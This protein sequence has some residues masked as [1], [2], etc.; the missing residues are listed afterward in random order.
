VTHTGSGRTR[1]INRIEIPL[2]VKDF[3]EYILTTP[4]IAPGLPQGLA[5]FFMRLLIPDEKSGFNAI[6][7]ET[8]EPLQQN[9]LPFILDIDVFREAAFEIHATEMWDTLERLRDFKNEIFFKS[10]TQ[11]A[12]ELFK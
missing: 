2:P 7:T 9:L 4:E 5:G 6:L 10:L 11:R 1:Y 8:M 12:Q 3:R